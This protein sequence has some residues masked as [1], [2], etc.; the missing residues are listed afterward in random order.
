M[1]Y[2]AGQIATCR[3]R[4]AGWL[5]AREPPC[6]VDD[7]GPFERALK[8]T[9]IERLGGRVAGYARRDVMVLFSEKGLVLLDLGLINLS[10][11]KDWCTQGE[12][13][14]A[15]LEKSVDKHLGP[16]VG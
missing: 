12:R 1:S 5:T 9:W 2:A 4:L 15:G 16:G 10:F 13:G 6:A 14:C 11:S 8:H 7:V 3:T